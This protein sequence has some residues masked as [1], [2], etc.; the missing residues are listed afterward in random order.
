MQKVPAY[1]EAFLMGR[2][3]ICLALIMIHP[4]NL[5]RYYSVQICKISCYICRIFKVGDR[6]L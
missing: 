4:T 3:A 2:I 6:I 1:F 5:D